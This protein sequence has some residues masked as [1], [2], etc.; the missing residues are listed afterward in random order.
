M[1]YIFMD[2]EQKEQ[3][4]QKNLQYY[5]DNKAEISQRQR[6]Y[7]REWSTMDTD[8]ITNSSNPN[9]SHIIVRRTR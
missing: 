9:R 4:R 3:I 7:F 6:I 8:G 2:E 1:K 5:H